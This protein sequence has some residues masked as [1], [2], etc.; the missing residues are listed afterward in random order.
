MDKLSKLD[1]WEH[2]NT[3]E[4]L[5]LELE[6]FFSDLPQ[7]THREEMLNAWSHG[8]IAIAAVFGSFYLMYCALDSG[9]MYAV[10]SAF[11]YGISLILLFG[12]SALYHGATNPSLKKK[13]RI[14]DHCAIFF[15]IAGNYTPLLL[16]TVGGETGWSLLYLQWSAAFIGILLKIRFTGK[17]DWMFIVLFVTM[18]WGGVAQGDFLYQTLPSAA[19]NWLIIGGIVYMLGIFFY[20]SEERIPYAHLIWHLFVIGGALIHYTIMVQYVF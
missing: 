20:K 2:H 10:E 9:K 11:V 5:D 15:F 19:I 18:A 1:T 3:Y 17:Y 13:M 7:R 6:E 16:L 4:T 8:L 14:L 12:A